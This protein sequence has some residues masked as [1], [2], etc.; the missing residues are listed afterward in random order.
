[1]SCMNYTWVAAIQISGLSPKQTAR[2]KLNRL[3]LRRF[4]KRDNRQ[5]SLWTAQSYMSADSRLIRYCSRLALISLS[6]LLR[7][8][9]TTLINTSRLSTVILVEGD[10]TL[11]IVLS[12]NMLMQLIRRK[13]K[14]NLTGQFT[15]VISFLIMVSIQGIIGQAIIQA[16]LTSRSISD[17]LPLSPI[18]APRSTLSMPSPIRPTSTYPSSSLI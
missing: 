5:R 12:K 8:T 16:E 6:S 17:N 11:C 15:M 18:P 7:R 3:M 14:S 10:S 2:C 4:K 13:R 9:I 1:M